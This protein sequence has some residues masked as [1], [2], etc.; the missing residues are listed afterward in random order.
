MAGKLP[1]ITN[2]NVNTSENNF[3]NIKNIGSYP[4]AISKVGYS[5]I[6]DVE[7]L[8]GLLMVI[9]AADTLNLIQIYIGVRDNSYHIRTC[10]NEKWASWKKIV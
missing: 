2:A 6:P 3:N 5:N 9:Q 1:Y 7:S 4:F 8:E 10:Y